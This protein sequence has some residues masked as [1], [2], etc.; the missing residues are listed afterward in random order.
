MTLTEAVLIFGSIIVTQLAM[1][2]HKKNKD[3]AFNET[4]LEK[5]ENEPIYCS[6]RLPLQSDMNKHLYQLWIFNQ[7]EAP[8]RY[9]FT[10]WRENEKVWVELFK[11]D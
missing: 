2:L 6:R 9:F 4:L 7:A 11:K 5:Y 8:K 10:E 3:L 1:I